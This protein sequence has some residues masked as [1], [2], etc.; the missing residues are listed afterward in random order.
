MS[1]PKAVAARFLCANLQ[2]PLI[3]AAALSIS[4]CLFYAYCRPE[5]IIL[6]GVL[7]GPLEQ[8]LTLNPFLRTIVDAFHTGWRGIK[9]QSRKFGELSI[10][11]ALGHLICDVPALRKLAGFLSH[12]AI[13]CCSKCDVET[14]YE[15]PAGHTKALQNCSQAYHMDEYNALTKEAIE[16]AADEILSAGNPSARG[17]AEKKHGFRHSVLCQLPKFDVVQYV[18]N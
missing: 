12:S 10:R 17:E 8:H 1:W 6:L 15:K 11:F 14:P 18:D 16:V 9:V 13:K 2:R 5:N 7:E 3:S 4:M